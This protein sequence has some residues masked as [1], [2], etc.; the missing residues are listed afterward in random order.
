LDRANWCVSEK[1]AWQGL[2]PFRNAYGAVVK[3]KRATAHEASVTTRHG[4]GCGCEIAF[5][6]C[7][8][9]LR[10]VVRPA[11]RYTASS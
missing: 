3:A 6:P 10:E 11:T 5:E 7:Q 4:F 1:E 9:N 2:G 8:A